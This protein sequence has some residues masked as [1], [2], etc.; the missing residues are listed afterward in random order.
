MHVLAE[1]N[2][3]ALSGET[4]SFLVGG[5][6]PI[7]VAQEQ[8]VI[9]VE[10][11]Q[12]GISLAFVPTV[13]NDGR[14][15]MRVRPEV[16]QL[17]NQGAVQ[18]SSG[19][20]SI[21]I[22]AL[23]VRRA[24]TTVE[25][26]SGQSFAI[27]GLLSDS[28][29]QTGTGVPFLGDVPI[30][31]A[32][33]RSDSFL[34]AQTELVI[35]VT[36]FIVRPV[37]DSAALRVPGEGWKPPNDIERILLLRQSGHADP[38]RARTARTPAVRPSMPRPPWPCMCPAMPG[39]SCNEALS[40][41]RPAGRLP[42]VPRRLRGHR[43]AA[44]QRS[45]ASRRRQREQYRSRSGKPGRSRLWPRAPARLGW[46]SR[47]RSRAAAAPGPGETAARQPAVRHQGAIER[48]QRRTGS[49][50]AQRRGRR[51]MP[52][53]VGARA[54]AAAADAS[55]SGRSRPAFV[56]FIADA[57]SEATL[58]QGLQDVLPEG[59]TIHRGN[60]RA[61]VAALRKMPTPRVLVVDVAGEEQPLSVLASLSEV[62]EPDVRVLVVG[63]RQDVNLY[64]QLT[65]GLGV[66]EYLYKPLSAEVV[67]QLFGPFLGVTTQATAQVQGGRVVTLTGACGGAGASTLAANLA[68]HLATEARRHT[69]L[70]DPDLH[71]GTV[72]MLLAAK[73]GAGLRTAI[74]TPQRIDELFME[75]IAQPA[76]ERLAVIAGEEK[77]TELPVPAANCAKLLLQALRQRYNYVV[78]DLPFV[79]QS[80]TRELLDHARQRVV[81]LEPTLT[82]VRD[83]LRL[84]ALPM[85]AQQARRA[86]VVLNKL[87]APGTM[88][89]RQVEDALQ[90]KIDVVVPFLPRLVVG[91]A[92]M[93]VPAAKTRGPFSAAV[94]DLAREVA[95]VSLAAPRR[96]G[97]AALLSRRAGA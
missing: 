39:S 85:G 14:I 54:P 20:S 49:R 47:R 72:A 23:Q 83:T 38:A 10:F 12:Y 43:S 94:H 90:Q 77:L 78:I 97:L 41:P 87:G 67:A 70:L 18:L 66:A 64:R 2:L 52:D 25:L 69:V 22:P 28:V 92:T 37:S 7:P 59:L 55:V 61:A 84:L 57:E 34:R 27:A 96:R 86:L 13:M 30:L 56:A 11:K 60:G 51:V 9:S 88:N 76:G 82:A 74:E 29:T 80:F 65:R 24:D 46:A 91:A 42:A 31:G 89:R 35:L 21:T 4:A 81:V 95:A 36:P 53:D 93:G 1:P 3:T 45:V 16:S 48:Q 17:T 62:V 26:G 75:R 79:P 71:T 63:D 73:T 40:S 58:R 32:L 6:F 15:N 8:G 50:R 33:F 44:P 5:E 19:N 68:W